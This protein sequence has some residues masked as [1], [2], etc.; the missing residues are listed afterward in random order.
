[1]TLSRNSSLQLRRHA[2]KSSSTIDTST[3]STK[4]SD[5]QRIDEHTSDTEPPTTTQDSDSKRA[6]YNTLKDLFPPETSDAPV[7]SHPANFIDDTCRK[8][9]FK[10]IGRGTCGIVFAQPESA[11]VW[12]QA[13]RGYEKPLAYEHDLQMKTHHVFEHLR[14][15]FAGT[16]V[17]GPN[18]EYVQSLVIPLIPAACTFVLEWHSKNTEN[19]R[20][21]EHSTDITCS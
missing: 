14:T 4:S 21:G 8:T 6:A 3:T 16:K 19:S 2:I 5:Q 9:S 1:M 13:L 18:N 20:Q 17:H 12:K 10:H 7:V 15:H 11:L